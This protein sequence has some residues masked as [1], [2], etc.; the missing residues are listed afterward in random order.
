MTIGAAN[1]SAFIGA[2]GPYWRD[3]DRDGDVDSNELSPDAIGVHVTDLDLGVFVGADLLGLGAYVAIKLD[4][5]DFGL[6]GIPGVELDGTL[7]VDLNLGASLMNGGAAIDFLVS[8][9]D[10]DGAGT[11]DAAGFEVDT[12]DPDFPVLLDF[13]GFLIDVEA[14]GTLSVLGVLNFLGAFRLQADANSLKI[15]A[16]ASLE[17]GPDMGGGQN[18]LDI[19]ALGVLILDDEGIAAD[20]DVSFALGDP[21]SIGFSV[22]ARVLLN[23]TLHDKSITVSDRFYQVVSDSAATGNGLAQKLKERL[24]AN[25]LC[26]GFHCYVIQ[27]EAPNILSG[28]APDLTNVFALLFG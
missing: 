20:V 27:G 10:E 11:E 18:L 21:S 19:S 9:P 16:A 5:E 13:T 15:L 12:G 1:V 7:S 26:G 28:T 3:T 2:N 4:I 22:R 23:S 17:I 14:I 25:P 6:V 8:F 24:D